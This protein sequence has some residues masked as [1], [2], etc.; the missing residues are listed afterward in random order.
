MLYTRLQILALPGAVVYEDASV[1]RKCTHVIVYES[2]DQSA[3]KP[4]VEELRKICSREGDLTTQLV[5]DKVCLCFCLFLCLFVYFLSYLFLIVLHI[6]LLFFPF[7]PF[8]DRTE[9]I[10]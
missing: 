4:Y 1:M 9:T 2:S 7:L 10:L 5:T 6:V 8:S 3:Y